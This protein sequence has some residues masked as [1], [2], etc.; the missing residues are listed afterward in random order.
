[1]FSFLNVQWTLIVQFYR[2]I[3]KVILI[4]Y[5]DKRDNLVIYFF[6]EQQPPPPR[7]SVA[8]ASGVSRVTLMR[9]LIVDAL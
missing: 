8:S 4:F 6:H 9:D 7:K 5:L 1:M 3:L 2:I